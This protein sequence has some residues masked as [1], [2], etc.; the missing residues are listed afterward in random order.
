M[1]D[2]VTLLNDHQRVNNQEREY[3]P[4]DNDEANGVAAV[5]HPPHKFHNDLKLKLPMSSVPE[6]SDSAPSALD[7]F[8]YYVCMYIYMCVCVYI[9]IYI[10]T[11]THTHTH[12]YI[13]IYI[14]TRTHGKRQIHAHKNT[15][16]Y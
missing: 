6:T 5:A 11:H 9:Y 8:R 7:A 13:H 14:D 10:H 16:R 4:R 1:Y 3:P 15:H 2:D 12:T